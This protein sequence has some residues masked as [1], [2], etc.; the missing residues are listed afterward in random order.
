MES[1][2]IPQSDYYFLETLEFAVVNRYVVELELAHQPGIWHKRFLE[3]VHRNGESVFLETT[4]S[5]Q[6]EES[7]IA[8]VKVPF[9]PGDTDAI[10]CFCD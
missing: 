10:S 2:I 8:A 1:Y 7:R 6:W 4:Q 9:L 3:K 5:E